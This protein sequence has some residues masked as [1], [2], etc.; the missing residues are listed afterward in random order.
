[1]IAALAPEMAV[2]N[3]LANKSLVGDVLWSRLVNRVMKDHE[4]Q[5]IYGHESVEVQS[6]IAE[7]IMDQ[8]VSFL[9]VVATGTDG[10]YSPSEQ[11]DIGWHTFI[12]YTREYGEFCQQIAGRMIHHA[13]SDVPGVTYVKGNS[14]RT[15]AV[16]QERGMF[17]DAALWPNTAECSDSYCTGDS[18]AGSSCD[19]E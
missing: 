12:V 9:Q 19:G 11:V 15:V 6:D 7:S 8:T 10:P 17:V 13:P 2:V 14:A 1:M 4:F 18:C 16:M 5:D 3:P